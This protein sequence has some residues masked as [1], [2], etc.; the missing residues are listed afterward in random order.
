MAKTIIGLNDAKAVQ[1]Y[2]SAL[3]VDVGRESYFDQRFIGQGENAKAPIVRLTDLESASGEKIS[4]DLSMQLTGQPTEGD[5]VME[6]REESLKFYTDSVYIDQIRHAVDTGGRMTK[7]RT[8]HDLRATAKK[9]LAEY[10]ARLFDEMLFIYLSGA[11]GTNA[12]FILPTGY[13][14]F[15]NNTVTAPDSSHL[16]FA[17]SVTKGTMTADNKLALSDIDK[18]VTKAS[19]MGGGSQGVPQIR[20]I[21][22]EG[23]EAYVLVM[24]PQQAEDLRTNATTGAWLDIQKALATAVGKAS[25]IFKGGLGMHN[26]VVLHSHKGCVRF[27]DYGSGAVAAARALFMGV[28]AGVIAFGSPGGKFRFDWEEKAF[29]YGNQVGIETHTIL[30]VKKTTFNSLDFGVIAIDSAAVVPS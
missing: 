9:R 28:Q 21:S 15:A 25:P 17:G 26:G 2:A 5:T 24:N 27:T 11:R 14:G 16:M 3:A 7:K 10:W 20:P 13:T 29:D 22:F 12:D 8:L 19:M 23:E 4:F 18:A 6:G 1:R 30:G